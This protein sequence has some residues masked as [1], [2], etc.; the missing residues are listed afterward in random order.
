MLAIQHL[1]SFAMCRSAVDQE[2]EAL[3]GADAV[4]VDHPCEDVAIY[5]ID[6]FV[7]H[8]VTLS[9]EGPA[10]F[11]LSVFLEG[12]GA[13]SL[14]GAQP[15]LIEPG[16][17]ALFTSSRFS[18][19]QNSVRGGQRLLAVDIRF[20][21][22]FLLKAGGA[23]LAT[24]GGSLATDHSLPECQ[25]SLVG[26]RAPPPLLKAA[27]D[28]ITCRLTDEMS[29]RLYLYSRAI[30]SLS[31]VTSSL[32]QILA[33]PDAVR[34]KDRDR[35]ERARQIIDGQYHIDW[36][37][38]RLAR[39]VGLNERKLKQ[40]FR[41]VVG[42]SVHSYLRKIRLDAAA[43]LLEDGH[44]VTEAAFSVGFDN[45]SHFSKIFRAEKGLAPSQYAKRP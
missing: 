35:L 37:I 12:R 7:P 4:R 15:L 13:V 43:T 32:P 45:L 21:F 6:T 8:D 1:D 22:R 28:I 20:D 29:R 38:A 40:G 14:D 41:Q 25:T 26:F 34:G 42:N 39:E 27:Q 9:Q 18:R 44:S 36:T 33:R 24:L 16:M 10:T 19:G 31:V 3:G 17:A 23:A 2:M 30:E 11:S 5:I